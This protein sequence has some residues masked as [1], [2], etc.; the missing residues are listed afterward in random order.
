M[1]WT[2][3]LL[4]LCGRSIV[5][6]NNGN[7]ALPVEVKRR[8]GNPGHQSLRPVKSVSALPVVD[9]SR[10]LS[11]GVAGGRVWD[12]VLVACRSWVAPSD[13][14]ALQ[15]LCEIVDE[16]AVMREQ[17]E[18]EGRVLVSPNGAAQSHPLLA[19]IRDLNKQIQGLF[20]SFGLTPSDRGRIGLGEVTAKSKLQA[21]ID[22]ERKGR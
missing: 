4:S 5:P 3:L 20:C 10:P 9:A 13:L 17:V 19:H 6:D 2:C 12:D 16:V 8:R 1:K 22:A 15:H 21:L 11:L 7:K 18:R 14:L